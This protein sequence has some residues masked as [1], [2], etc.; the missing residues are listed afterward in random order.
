MSFFTI[1]EMLDII[2]ILNKFNM[3]KLIFGLSMYLLV[4]FL[5]S[6]SQ[7]SASSEPPTEIASEEPSCNTRAM[8]IVQYSKQENE[9][10]HGTP[11]IS[12]FVISENNCGARF[13]SSFS[14]NEA[15]GFDGY[16]KKL[17]GSSMNNRTY[18][19]CTTS[20]A[21]MENEGISCLL[22]FGGLTAEA[23]DSI[24]LQTFKQ[25]DELYEGASFI[26]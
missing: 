24:F 11:W 21:N 3:K 14:I 9:T 17:D 5:P 25:R 4:L 26:F 18:R 19:A 6:C 1:R 7:P 12:Y 16:S 22:K 2:L 13:L 20:P 8:K 23:V 15:I 10:T